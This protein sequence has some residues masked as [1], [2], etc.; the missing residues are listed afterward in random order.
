M[1]THRP[2]PFPNGWFRVAFSRQLHRDRV[3]R[4][5]CFG[6]ELVAFRDEEGQARVLDAY[7]PHLGAHLGVGSRI[8]GG[9]VVCPFHGWRYDGHGICVEAPMA[10]KIPAGACVRAWAV[11]EISHA[12]LIWHHAEGAEPDWEVA[13]VAEHDLAGVGGLGATIVKWD[14]AAHPQEI[15]ENTVD[16]LH[17]PVLHGGSAKTG[18]VADDLPVVEE[19]KQDG[20]RLSWAVRSRAR[21]LGRPFETLIRLQLSGPGI[22]DVRLDGTVSAVMRRYLTPVDETMTLHRFAI[23]ARRP[24][25]LPARLLAQALI[26]NRA[27]REV[28]QDR[29]IWENKTFLQKPLLCSADGPIGR[30][31]RY[32]RQFYSPSAQAGV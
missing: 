14:I 2:P 23:L 29:P 10:K 26:A 28:G 1:P 22:L 18:F 31:R 30:Y 25:W 3:E 4:L 15:A 5:R 7:C 11:R 6:R 8:E 20:P 9:T 19:M 32:M 12:I 24:R 13:P 27:R 21:I 17:F 16:V